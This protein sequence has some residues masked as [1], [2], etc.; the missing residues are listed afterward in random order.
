MK[1]FHISKSGIPSPCRAEKGNCPL[2]SESQHFSTIEAAQEKA[3]KLAEET[4]GILPEI[5]NNELSRE[6]RDKFLEHKD[7]N[8]FVKENARDIVS[9]KLFEGEKD[10]RK[11][12]LEKWKDIHYENSRSHLSE[13]DNETS[14]RIVNE[15]MDSSELNGWFREY[16]SDYKPKIEQKLITNAELRNASLNIAHK[17]YNE[18]T[19]ENTTYENFLEKEIELYRGGNFDF[20]EKDVF[21][22]YSFDKKVAEKFSKNK[23]GSE[24]KTLKVKAIEILGSLQTTGEAEV[25][26]RRKHVEI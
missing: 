8:Q 12:S 18:K 21:I 23:K 11:S 3:N 26:I 19:G 20:I 7:F 24:I 1:V 5:N 22:S 15:N 2:G 9:E 16:D 17:L 25:M 4:Y 13:L 10:L 6:W 14:I